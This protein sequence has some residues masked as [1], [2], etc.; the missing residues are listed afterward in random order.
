TGGT[1]WDPTSPFAYTGPGLIGTFNPNGN[2]EDIYTGDVY[3]ST[4]CQNCDYINLRQFTE[5]QPEFSRANYNLKGN[6][7]FSADMNGYFS[8]KYINSKGQSLGQPFFRFGSSYGQPSLD[9]TD[10]IYRD[11]AF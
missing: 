2:F 8:A 9:G 10:T 4:H 6:Y 3:N 1:V 7:E 5:V 11:N